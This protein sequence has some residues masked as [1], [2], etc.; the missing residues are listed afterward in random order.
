MDSDSPHSAR[1]RDCNISN[2]VVDCKSVHGLNL[3]MSPRSDYKNASDDKP[4]C[5][6]GNLARLF[7]Q[8]HAGNHK[9]AVPPA[10]N[11]AKSSAPFRL[12][13]LRNVEEST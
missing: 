7:L 2:C 12:R 11:L 1:I 3:R 5:F 13:C 6:L 4:A 9:S 8:G 10:S